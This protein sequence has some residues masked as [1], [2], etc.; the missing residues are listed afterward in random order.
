M[1]PRAIFLVQPHTLGQS[2]R[3]LWKT[4]YLRKDSRFYWKIFMLLNSQTESVSSSLKFDSTQTSTLKTCF[5][6]LAPASS[7]LFCACQP[8][9][10]VVSFPHVK[11]TNVTCKA[12]LLHLKQKDD[13][14]TQP[15]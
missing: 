8:L 9:L 15:S 2:K 6:S 12:L 3:K 7:M 13:I 14:S 11:G 5:P 10:S 1:S 4:I